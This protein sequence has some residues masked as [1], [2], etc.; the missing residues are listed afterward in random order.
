MLR[1][2]RLNTLCIVHGSYEEQMTPW[3]ASAQL[4]RTGIVDPVD[5]FVSRITAL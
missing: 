1:V 2:M 4:T 5:A 3:M